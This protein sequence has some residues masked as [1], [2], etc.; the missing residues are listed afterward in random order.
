MY[1]LSYDD[2]IKNVETRAEAI[3]QAKEISSENNV[4]VTLQD[5][6]HRERMI[7]QRGE[8]V[9]YDYETRKR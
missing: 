8:L 3:A 4:S 9:S 7:Y 6:G 5:E 1:E 2:V